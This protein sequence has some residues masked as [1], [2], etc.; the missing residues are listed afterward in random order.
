MSCLLD[1]LRKE[2][3]QT[4]IM[5]SITDWLI[6]WLVVFG[7]CT[8]RL[9]VTMEWDNTWVFRCL[10]ITKYATFLLV[11]QTC[12]GMCDWSMNFCRS[13]YRLGI[14]DGTRHLHAVKWILWT[15][16]MLTSPSLNL[17]Q[18]NPAHCSWENFHWVYMC[19]YKNLECRYLNLEVNPTVV[20]IQS[21][22]FVKNDLLLWL[23]CACFCQ[24]LFNSNP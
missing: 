16:S 20:S 22:Q 13:C 21:E 7:L 3:K 15:C 23:E 2:V 6:D 1:F 4:I 19:T 11:W 18:L 10:K 5:C 9:E 12:H 8:A 24:P 14:S 17:F